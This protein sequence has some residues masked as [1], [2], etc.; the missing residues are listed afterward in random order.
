MIFF[1]DT[2]NGRPP[3]GVICHIDVADGVDDVQKS[4]LYPNTHT[5]V[6]NLSILIKCHLA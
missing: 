6:F 4:H 5:T 1:S 3:I 2:K